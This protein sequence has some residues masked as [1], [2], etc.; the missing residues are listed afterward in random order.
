MSAYL[1]LR[2]VPWADRAWIPGRRDLTPHLP[3]LRG[4]ALTPVTSADDIGAALA[5]QLGRCDPATTGLLLSGGIDS[6]ILA[7]LLPRGVNTYTIRFVAEDAVDETE[8]A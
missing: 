7:A 6:A 5:A 2:Y 1:A 8:R 4:A 3:E